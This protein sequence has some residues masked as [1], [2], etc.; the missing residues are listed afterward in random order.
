LQ[1]LL[2]VAWTGFVAW[3]NPLFL[4]W[5]LPVAGALI[6]SIP[7]SVY[8]SRVSLGQRARRAGVFVIPEEIHPPREIRAARRYRRTA[9]PSRTF[10]DAAFDPYI[11]ALVCAM[12]NGGRRLPDAVRRE[13]VLLAQDAIARGPVALNPDQKARLLGD[14][15]A[16]SW[17]HSELWERGVA[18]A[19]MPIAREDRHVQSEGSGGVRL[20][21]AA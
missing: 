12:P 21:A 9:A 15:W 13:R 7:L 3:L 8:T 19:H 18:S 2:G 16:L 11:N 1:T 14:P 17:L 20:P 10:V 5:V 6:L 4:G